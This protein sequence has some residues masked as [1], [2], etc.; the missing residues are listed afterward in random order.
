MLIAYH[1]TIANHAFRDFWNMALDIVAE[2]T[3]LC[4]QFQELFPLADTKGVTVLEDMSALTD[5]TLERLTEISAPY[6]TEPG[7]PRIN[8]RGGL[9]GEPSKERFKRW[10]DS[11]GRLITYRE[12]GEIRGFSFFFERVPEWVTP[13]STGFSPKDEPMAY[14]ALICKEQ[15]LTNSYAAKAMMNSMLVHLQRSGTRTVRGHY[16]DEN[17]PAAKLYH[18]YGASLHTEDI[19]QVVSSGGRPTGFIG[20]TVPVDPLMRIRLKRELRLDGADLISLLES[21]KLPGVFERPSQVD[22]MTRQYGGLSFAE[23]ATHLSSTSG[24]TL[25]VIT[26][27]CADMSLM[28][29]NGAP[30]YF[31]RALQGYNGA[32][33]S[34]GNQ[35]RFSVN[36]ETTEH[37]VPGIMDL[38]PL[39]ST[40]L[41]EGARTLG[42]VPVDSRWCHQ[43]NAESESTFVRPEEAYP[44]PEGTVHKSHVS[45]V[46][47]GFE[48]LQFCDSR[49]FDDS[50]SVWKGE[51]LTRIALAK[52][53]EERGITPIWLVFNGGGITKFEMEEVPWN[54]VVLNG[55]GRIADDDAFVAGLEEKAVPVAYDPDHPEYLQDTLRS[56]GC[57]IPSHRVDPARVPTP[58]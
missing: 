51:A 50:V 1:R 58:A 56:L 42:V 2:S 26:G 20:F 37:V 57:D 53:C 7:D 21:R 39:L 3:E 8:Q 28:N 47:P 22:E 14:L 31:L 19:N 54:V 25:L 4:N 34:G 17:L 16:Q 32:I 33:M 18:H 9:I 11:G 29:W 6:R 55:S 27:G 44:S 24:K 43:V 45:V 15:S 49:N 30:E 23:A 10:A 41:D 13:P 40:E 35:M 12:G 52:K 38:I 48:Y 46:H 5:D 36:G